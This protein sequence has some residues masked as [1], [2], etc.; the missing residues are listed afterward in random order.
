MAGMIKKAIVE[1]AAVRVTCPNCKKVLKWMGATTTF[2]SEW[3]DLWDQIL[4]QKHL[5]CP[6]CKV[7]FS[8]PA[9]PFPK[10]PEQKREERSGNV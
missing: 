10:K 6:H 8:L 2:S 5:A 1:V 3:S 4:A 9:N 7:L